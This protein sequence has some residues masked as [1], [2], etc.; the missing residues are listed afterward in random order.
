MKKNCLLYI[1]FVIIALSTACNRN[2]NWVASDLTPEKSFTK[3]IEGPACFRFGALYVVNFQKDSTIGIIDST[4][5]GDIL[6]TLPKGSMGNGIR[7]DKASNM[8]IADY[9]KHNILVIRSGE[10][11]IDVFAHDSTMD[12]PNDIAITSKGIL[13]AS[14]PDWKNSTGKIYR[15][16]PNGKIVKIDSGMGTTN[17]IEVSPGDKYLY[18]NESI[19]RK[20]WRYQLDS[21]GN[22]YG[23][24]LF[25]SFPDY[26]LDGMRCDT[27]GNLYVCRYDK[28]TVAILSPEGKLIREVK[29]K[30]KKVSNIA[31][32]GSNGKTCY[33]TIQDRGCVEKF[34]SETPGREWALFQ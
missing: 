31:F 29:L 34:K 2:K 10:L 21:A 5:K 24:K 16:D 18:V 17:G 13:F 3:N 6:V 11:K 8:Y 23:K 15:I 14:D 7:F 12:G 19:Q 26:G 32:G 25:F 33:V 4:G 27:I 20:I 9:G 1:T 22:I 28:G 30:G